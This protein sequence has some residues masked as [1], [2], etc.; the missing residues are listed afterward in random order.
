MA[1]SLIKLD[2][3]IASNDASITLGASNWDSSYDVYMVRL[4][5]VIPD[6]DGIYL[7]CRVTVPTPSAGTPDTSANYDRAG[8]NLSASAFSN[9][10]GTNETASYV[11]N[12]PNGTG[13]SE[14]TN[15]ILYLFNF[16]NSSEYS[17]MTLETSA[18][19]STPT[20]FGT[21]GG[22]VHTVAQTCDGIQ[23][24]FNGGNINSGVFT[25]YG[26]KK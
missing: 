14:S 1:G 23:F 26:L 16:N 15:G 20:H 2:E 11:L 22:I 21:Q 6:T 5:N 3:K 24:Y 17:F 10:S 25:L 4:N 13:T 7:R 8:K 12:N 9:G 19:T 18:L